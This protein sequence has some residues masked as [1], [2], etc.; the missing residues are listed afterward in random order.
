MCGCGGGFGGGGSAG[1]TVPAWKKFSVVHTQFQTAGL[2]QNILLYNLPAGGLIHGVKLKQS[3]AFAGAGITGYFLS[4]G[5]VGALDDL[6]IEYTVTP[7]PA[8]DTFAISQTFD[9]RNHSAA[10]AVQIAARSTGANLS[11]STA[12]AADIWLLISRPI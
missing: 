9:S 8:A 5:F 4:L 2:T 11:A 3:I 10:V 12:G 1:V 6:L 7:A